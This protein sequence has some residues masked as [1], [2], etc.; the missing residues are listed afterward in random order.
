MKISRK[1]RCRRS[2][3]RFTVTANGRSVS[4]PA[5]ACFKASDFGLA[6]FERGALLTVVAKGKT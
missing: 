4:K 3:M 6:A 1:A 2:G 5:V